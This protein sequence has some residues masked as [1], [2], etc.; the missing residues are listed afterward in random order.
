MSMLCLN[1]CRSCVP[2]VISLGVCFIKKM[3]SS[4]LARLRDTASKFALFSVSS[5]KDKKLTKKQ[6]YTKTEI[7]KLYSRVFWIFL[8][9]FIKINRY[10]FVLYRFKFGAFFLRHSVL[11]LHQYRDFLPNSVTHPHKSNTE[12]TTGCHDL[13]LPTEQ[14]KTKLKRHCFVEHITRV[15]GSP[16]CRAVKQKMHLNCTE[17]GYSTKSHNGC[18]SKYRL[19]KTSLARINI[20]ISCIA[21]LNTILQSLQTTTNTF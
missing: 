11:R 2:N 12:Y 9:N 13:S 14:F 18:N 10:N 16:H 15:C 17:W 7:C 5:L 19:L 21:L 4:K 1:V 20:L 6:A 8:P 3:Y